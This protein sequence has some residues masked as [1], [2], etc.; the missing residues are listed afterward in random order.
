MSKFEDNIEKIDDEDDDIKELYKRYQL[1][2]YNLR[3]RKK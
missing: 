1:E 3:T 2:L